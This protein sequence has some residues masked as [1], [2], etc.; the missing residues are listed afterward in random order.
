MLESLFNKFTG[1]QTGNLIKKRLQHKC[2]PVNIAKI[3]KSIYF[4]GHLWTTTSRL[5][6]FEVIIEKLSVIFIKTLLYPYKTAHFS[7]N[8]HNTYKNA[9]GN[10]KFNITKL[11]LRKLTFWKQP[12]GTGKR[13]VSVI[14]ANKSEVK[15]K[16]FIISILYYGNQLVVTPRLF[17]LLSL[18]LSSSRTFS[19]HLKNKKS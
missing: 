16:N 6:W 14:L 1:L 2:F 8:S 11:N 17:P 18:F 12:A 5:Y 13:W 10:S 9:D 4:K 3:F 7:N 19:R 15:A